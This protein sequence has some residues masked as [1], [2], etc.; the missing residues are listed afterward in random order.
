[1]RFM[2]IY[3]PANFKDMEAGVPPRQEHMAAMAELIGEL[4]Q[5]GL[6]I[7]TDG[8][9]GSSKGA[10]VK[11]ANGEITVTDGPFT[12]A[13]EL[14]GGYAIFQLQSKAEAIQL[15]ERFLKVAGDGEVEI[16]QMHDDP[17]GPPPK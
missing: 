15:T 5:K 9:Q 4:S 17:A 8:L 10:R 7:T 13:K 6:L 14:I 11:R 12:E 16:R 2:M 3:K 1:M